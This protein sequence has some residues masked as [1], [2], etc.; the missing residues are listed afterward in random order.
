M[1]DDGGSYYPTFRAV[2]SGHREGVETTA[3]LEQSDRGASLRDKMA[4]Q[5]FN[6]VLAAVMDRQASQFSLDAMTRVFDKAKAGGKIDMQEL[7]AAAK[8]ERTRAESMLEHIRDQAYPEA[9]D[10]AFRI[11]DSWLAARRRGQEIPTTAAEAAAG[12]SSE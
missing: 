9:S 8:A 12:R 4:M 7:I 5:V 2:F 1:I 11:A 6:G 3:T 10:E